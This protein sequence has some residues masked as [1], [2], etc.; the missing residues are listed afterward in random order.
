MKGKDKNVN[1]PDQTVTDETNAENKDTAQGSDIVT[2]VI[3]EDGNPPVQVT[4]VSTPPS[5]A[6][7]LS[8]KG[9]LNVKNFDDLTIQAQLIVFTELSKDPTTGIPNPAIGLMKYQ[10]A[11]ELK[12]PWANAS[13]HMHIIKGRVGLDIN[14]CQAIMTRPGSGIRWTYVEEYTPFY[15][16]IDVQGNIYE[17]DNLPPNIIPTKAWTDPVGVG[18]IAVVLKPT[19]IL[20]ADGKTTTFAYYPSNYRTIIKF[21]RK[22]K[23]IDGTWIEETEYGKFSWKDAL[24]AGLVKPD[25]N[26]EKRPA[27]M[28]WK[29]AYW[30]GAKKIANDLL[31]GADDPDMLNSIPD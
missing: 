13:S 2:E 22:K 25:S 1:Q 12:L 16:Y 4:P 27:F 9:T 14:L 7:T 15:D 19:P 18:N 29:S 28:I 21:T 31:M 17:G 26:W 30:D 5:T 6:I 8:E 23:D 10:R 3:E 11:K 24:R 20:S